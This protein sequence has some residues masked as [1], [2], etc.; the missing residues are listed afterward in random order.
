MEYVHLVGTEEMEQQLAN[1]QQQPLIPAG[2]KVFPPQLV[3]REVSSLPEGEAVL[4]WP[5]ALSPESVK[6]LE[7][8]LG[9]VVKKMKRRYMAEDK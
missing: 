1:N 4:Q 9:L 6:D 3:A 7:E 8:W 2:S 5:A